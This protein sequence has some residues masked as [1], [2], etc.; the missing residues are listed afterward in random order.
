MEDLYEEASVFIL[1][2]SVISPHSLECL[3]DKWLPAIQNNSPTTPF[4]LVATKNDLRQEQSIR[5][6][7][8]R[9]GLDVVQH[10]AGKSLAKQRGAY[11]FVEV[12]L[13]GSHCR[14]DA[15]AV[16]AAA[17]RAVKSKKN[18]QAKRQLSRKCTVI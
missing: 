18:S 6:R 4:I 7:L 5:R 17:A 1:C 2:Y 14:E 15:A 11:E 3:T 8:E 9:M 12:S 13:V 16:F 10:S